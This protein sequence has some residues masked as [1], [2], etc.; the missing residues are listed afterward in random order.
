MPFLMQNSKIDQI[1]L[2]TRPAFGL[3][4]KKSVTVDGLCINHSSL[5][6]NNSMNFL[7]LERNENLKES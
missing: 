1:I 6:R 4:G 3:S 5:S 2:S 7:K